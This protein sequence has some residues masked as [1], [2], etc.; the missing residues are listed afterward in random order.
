MGAIG[1]AVSTL[2][3][4]GLN[5]LKLGGMVEVIVPVSNYHQTK[6]C[7]KFMIFPVDD[8]VYKPIFTG[9]FAM[10]WLALILILI[11]GSAAFGYEVPSTVRQK[12]QALYNQAIVSHPD[13]SK[14]FG[15]ARLFHR[16]GIRVLYVKGDRFEMA[17][18]H[19]RLLRD[20]VHQGALSQ[21]ANIV[22][23]SARNSFPKIPAVVEPVIKVIYK[24]YGDNMLK[25][26][27]KTFGVSMDDFLLES[28]GL[29]EG[30]GFKL[31]DVVHAMLGPEILQVILGE[32]SSKNAPKPAGVNE[33]TDFAIG[34]SGTESGGYV[35]GR[36]TDYPL[37]GSFDRF[38]TVIYYH[39]TDGTQRSMAVTSAG[40]HMAGVVG[41]NE[42]GIFIGV[43]TIPTTQ[44]SKK[45]NPVFGVGQ[46]VLRNA[47]SFDE[48]V[49]IFKKMKPAAGWTYTLVSTRERRSGSVELTNQNI[50]VRETTGGVHIQTNHF[51]T[52]EM[53][54]ANL[55]LNASINEDT[56]A[57]YIRA[58]QLIAEM[59]G[60]MDPD[61][62]VRILSDKFDPFNHETRGLANVIAA[63]TTLT[64]AVFDTGAGHVFVASGTAPVSTTPYVE[65]PLINGFDPDKFGAEDF[66]VIENS[67]YHRDFPQESQAEQLYI[68]AKTAFESDIDPK[69]SSQI[70]SDVIAMDPK[71]AAYYFVRGIITL[72]AHNVA[73]AEQTFTAC[74]KLPYEHYR[75][76]CHYYLGRIAADRG[77]R[78]EAEAA[79]KIV[80]DQAV[81]EVEAPL[82][83]AARSSL[84]KVKKRGRLK[85][86]AD[87]IAI[88][89]PEADVVEY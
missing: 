20:E 17:F 13:G 33:C 9:D 73:D 84:D 49:A 65:L 57:R 12:Y 68:Q 18:Q 23:N 78:A 89:M 29:S 19:G 82:I 64:S 46:Y 79:F 11:P 55:D 38:P 70:L 67:S 26:G 83:R 72:K 28:Y 58:E 43:H 51:K 41:F 27:A 44:V 81:P 7:L 54:G 52:P 4:W 76:A 63:H 32:M 1:N 75:L 77:D 24:L 60:K 61:Y 39:P 71:N 62:A 16:G 21:V 47:R 42:S 25:H 87:T 35:I 6:L 69:K 50:A 15:E 34:P 74:T 36:N 86:N 5:L 66:G 88:F 80:L 30:S 53:Q 45:G 56:R 2:A 48:A 40:L 31:D 22:A 8:K 37:N 14:Q 10:N 59:P 85:L 3:G